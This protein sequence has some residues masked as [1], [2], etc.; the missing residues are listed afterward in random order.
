MS[1]RSTHPRRRAIVV[2]ADRADCAWL[3]LLKPGFRHCFAALG[4]RGGWLILDPLLDRIEL[5][6]VQPDQ[7][8]DLPSFYGTQGHTVLAGTTRR[9]ERP[10]RLPRLAP[11]T[12]VSVVKRLLGL[13]APGVLTPW[14][15]FRHLTSRESDDFR[16]LSPPRTTAATP[17]HGFDSGC[18]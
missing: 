4:E 1:G 11:L 2:F 5:T 18:D 15:L 7:D 14:Q 8:F 13:N 9:P 16:Q 10:P 12:C 6:W 17:M 3:R